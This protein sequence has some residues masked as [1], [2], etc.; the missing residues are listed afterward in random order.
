MTVNVI[1]LVTE[2]FF[3][4]LLALSMLTSIFMLVWYIVS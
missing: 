3:D 4:V 1:E 2:K